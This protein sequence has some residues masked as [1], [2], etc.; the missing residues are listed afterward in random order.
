MQKHARSK[1]VV[2]D[3]WNERRKIKPLEFDGFKSNQSEFNYTEFGLI[4]SIE[5]DA[6]EIIGLKLTI[7]AWFLWIATSFS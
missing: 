6:F 5:F 2:V 7:W 4:K 3:G 1:C